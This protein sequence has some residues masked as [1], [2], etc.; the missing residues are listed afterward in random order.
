MQ[1]LGATEISGDILDLGCGPGEVTLRL[2]RRFPAANITAIDGSEAMIRLAKERLVLELPGNNRVHF[3]QAM[4]PGIDISEKTYE[5]IVSTSFLH[6]LHRPELLWQTIIEHAGPGTK[7]FI[8]DLCRPES[9]NAARK[10]VRQ[11]A[12]NEP[13]ILQQ[14][15]Y[16]SLLAAFTPQEIEKQLLAAG[17]CNLTVELNDYLIVYGEI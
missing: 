11:S 15:F 9:K 1:D 7:V 4:V 13:D 16:N 12:S 10:M 2:A 3:I 5:L 17:L 8:A 14:D 6:H